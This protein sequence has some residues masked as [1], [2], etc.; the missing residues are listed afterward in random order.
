MINISCIQDALRSKIVFNLVRRPTDYAD[1]PYGVL[2]HRYIELKKE[3]PVS[4]NVLY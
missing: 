3:L 1:E 2:L 4:G